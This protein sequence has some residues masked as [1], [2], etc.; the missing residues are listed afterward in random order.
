MRK[1]ETLHPLVREKAEELKQRAEDEL[2]LRTVIT[3]CLR[4]NEEQVALYAQGR[5]QLSVTNALRAEA[6]MPPITDAQNSHTVTK[7]A[8][9]ASSFHGYG[10]AWD[11]AVLS[12]D[13]KQIDWSSKSDWNDDDVNDW[14]QLGE[15]AV[16]MGIEWGGQWTS[17]PD[18]PH[19]QMTFDKT[20]HAL[21]ADPLVLAGQTISLE[22]DD[23]EESE[24]QIAAVDTDTGTSTT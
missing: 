14:L 16:S 3:E 13:G 11:M 7:A 15:L 19:Y 12:P 5:K 6:G 8:N 18:M 23:E 10:L 21:K 20:I 17:Y 24:I 4:T 22:F 1:I 9:A 2:G